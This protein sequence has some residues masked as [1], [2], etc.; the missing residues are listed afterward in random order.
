MMSTQ[1]EQS[2]N[3]D[4]NGFNVYGSS[5]YHYEDAELL[6]KLWDIPIIEAKQAIGHKI[7]NQIENLLPEEVQAL[8]KKHLD[9]D[10]SNESDGLE[11]E[12]TFNAYANSTYHYED[13]E[14][15]AKLWDIPVLEA[16]HTIGNKVIQ[17]IENL[18]P[19]EVRALHQKHLDEGDETTQ[20][21]VAIEERQA[22]TIKG[23]Y[24][25]LQARVLWSNETPAGGL[26]VHVYDK[27]MINDDFLGKT[28]T[29]EDGGF[30]LSFTEKDFKGLFFDRKPDLY[31]IINNDEGEELFNT[32][33]SVIKNANEKTTP[34]TLIL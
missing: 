22:I 3:W 23:T 16:K 9:E 7:T 21:I 12:T 20:R 31:F 34:I 11:A 30:D 17:Q 15:L 10:D 4:S 13:A 18:L 6:A 26:L 19:E 27:D 25:L 2:S 33:E 32:K 28:I 5:A 8:H 1:D 29:A 14:L 24:Y